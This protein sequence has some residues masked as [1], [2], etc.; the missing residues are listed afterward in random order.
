[1]P[2][3]ARTFRAFGLPPG[4]AWC[5]RIAVAVMVVGTAGLAQA[6]K[7]QG[8]VS[9]Y[10]YLTNPVWD[11]AND[12]ERHMFS[13][14]EPVPTVRAEYRKLFPHIPKEL[15]VAALAATKQPP[16]K[17]I[18]VRVGGGRTTPVTIVVTPGTQLQFQNTDPFTHRLFGVGVK[19]FL[20]SET[21][22][23]GTRT[24]TVPEQ[25][26]TFEIRDEAAPSLR[27]WV[28]AEPNLA[29]IGYPSLSGQFAMNV[30]EPGEY[31]LQA[32]F[33]GKAVGEPRPIPVTGARDIDI[34]RLPIV[35]A[36]KQS[37][38]KKDD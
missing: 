26:G 23:G 16:Q 18:L 37:A 12:S 32:Y 29:A 9:G 31:K 14:R 20:P 11:E 21:V 27:M 6:A 24:W 5:L 10:E 3:S 38:S 19:S 36:T 22:K 7:I 15:C 13:F 1:M 30:S 17:P 35:V 34:S 25:A 28:V 8:K 4:T 2:K 33:A